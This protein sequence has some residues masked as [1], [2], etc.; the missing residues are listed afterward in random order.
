MLKN[1]WISLSI[2]M[3]VVL[4]LGLFSNSSTARSLGQRATDML[5]SDTRQKNPNIIIVTID[6]KAENEYGDP[7]SWSRARA[8]ELVETLNQPDTK[9]AVIAFDIN[10][11]SERDAEGDA[12]FVKAAEEGGN[13]VIASRL[14]FQQT[15]ELDETG[16]Y[17]RDPLHVSAF[18]YPFAALKEVSDYGFSDRVSDKDDYVR[19]ALLSATVDGETMYSFSYQAYLN[20]MEFLGKEP[21]VPRVDE[22]NLYGIRY[23]DRPNSYTRVSWAE[24]VNGEVDLRYFKD[25]VVLV[26]AYMPGMQDQYSVPISKG[27]VMHGVEIHANIIDSMCRGYSYEMVKPAFVTVF[28]IVICFLYLLLLRKTN[29]GIG[30]GGALVLIGG[31]MYAAEELYQKGWYVYPIGFAV[32]IVL[33]LAGHIVGKYVGEWLSKRR[34]MKEFK[35]YVAPQVLEQMN[36]SGELSIKLG[37]E[38]RDIAVLFVDIRGF[39]TLSEALSPEQ[40]VEMLNEYLALTTEAIF[41][42]GGTL[43]KFIG[44]ATM[45]VF[46]APVD[47]PDYEARAVQAALDIVHGAEKV[48]VKIK[49]KIGRE[50]AFGVGVNCGKAVVG[51]IGCETRMDYTAI[52]DTVN[53]AARL[54]GKALGGQVVISEN[55]RQRLHGRI[56]TE[57]LGEMALKGKA[58][59]LAVHSVLGFV[60]ETEMKN[61]EKTGE[62]NRPEEA[63]ATEEKTE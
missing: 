48:N 5:Y 6:E 2:T 40:V 42:N 31:Y 53:T 35:K 45:A 18:E 23:I 39:T 12:A 20:Y 32:C 49:E 59:P 57:P 34:I 27:D 30:I 9:P 37:G 63:I 38:S 33:M 60:Q 10:Y 4:L 22:A 7:T 44:D 36:K 26:G 51:N 46:N 16:E 21:Y 19:H 8:A 17:S 11:V 55:L 24:V 3:L 47:L 52:G 50:V 62:Q 1:K 41:A 14:I 25:C 54:E 28:N 58:E 61:E 29:L 15:T 43:D 13:V 56:I